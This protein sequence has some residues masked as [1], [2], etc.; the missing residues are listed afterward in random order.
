MSFP[1]TNWA[2]PSSDP[3]NL[4]FKETS[5]PFLG[6]HDVVQKVSVLVG[7]AVA[8]TKGT[9]GEKGLFNLRAHSPSSN[10][11][12]AGAQGLSLWQKPTE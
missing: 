12:K 4:Y 7:F 11:A 6:L 1:R 9:W 3:R 10:E 5:I 2:H 8:V